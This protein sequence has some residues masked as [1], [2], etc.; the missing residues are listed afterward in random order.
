MD[1]SQLYS[2]I[3]SFPKADL[4]IHVDGNIKK[5]LLWK[6][7]REYGVRLPTDDEKEFE[8]LYTINPINGVSLSEA[9]VLKR[10]AWPIAVMRHP[11]ALKQ[12]AYNQVLDLAKE[13]ILYAEVRF[14]PGYH[15][16]YPAP[17]YNPE[18]YEIDKFPIM[19][20]ETVVEKVLSGLEK[21]MKETGT[22]VNLTLSIPRET[23]K[24]YGVESAYEIA[25]LAIKYQDK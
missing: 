14:A 9:E 3:Y 19:S 25:R 1:E 17:F 16:K 6:L 23:I 22:Q 12:I 2:Q 11:E 15:S 18:D 24:Y 5:N 21:G 4:H 7:A 8:K 13:N 20:L 10:F